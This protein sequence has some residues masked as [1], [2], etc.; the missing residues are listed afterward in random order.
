MRGIAVLAALFALLPALPAM[1]VDVK[2][3]ARK[4]QFTDIKISPGGE[5]LA[6]TVP[7]EDRT[8]LAVLDRATR[9]LTGTFSLHRNTHVSDFHWVGPQRLVIGLAEKFGSLETP[10]RTGELFAVNADGSRAEMLAGFRVEGSGGTGTHIAP[11]KD[12]HRIAA[13]LVDSVPGDGRTALVSV[14]SYSAEPYTSVES[15]DLFTGRRQRVASAPVRRASFYTDNR[16]RVRF[17]AGADSD[18]VRK[19]YYRKDDDAD[20]ELLVSD[21]A[22]GRF[23]YPIGFSAD[24]SVV[25][26]RSEQPDGPDA[27]VALDLA[28]RQRTQVLR[29]DDVDPANIDYAYYN[30]TNVIYRPGT[31]VPVGVFFMDGKPRI[32]FFDE[33]APE[34]R[35]YRSLEAAFPGQAVEITSQTADGRLALVKVSSDRNP[36]DFYLFDTAAKKADYLLSRREWFDPARQAEVRPIRLTARDGLPLHGYLTLPPG[37]G[38]KGLPM[39]VMPHGGPFGAQDVWGFDG[40]AQMLAEAGYAV[41]QLNFRGSGGYGRAF[42][43]AGAREWGGKMQD[44]LTDATR[45]AIGQGIADRNRICLYGA[46]YGAYASLMGLAK[47]PGLYKCAAGYVGVY[48]LPKMVAEDARTGRRLSNWSREWVGDK[49]E[50]LAANSPNRIAER[51]EAPVFLAAGGQDPFAPIEHSRLME[52]ALRKAGV[53]VETLYF[54]TEGHGFYVEAHREAFYARLLAFLSRHLGGKVATTGGG[55]N[56][57]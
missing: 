16:G 23:E 22:S 56:A 28:T 6:A 39:V 24:D 5:Y 52:Q 20:W 8:V 11:K 3:Y 40:D 47:E 29:D 51:I 2:A 32:A 43:I 50:V 48:D 18:N 36:G 42:R 49:P 30:P 17:A 41:L 4:D 54:D 26:L 31:R 14:Q 25:Y 19:L 7:L 44:D 46:S 45:W 10:Q 38:G 27:V 53:P 21:D 35:L 37:G 33:K 15:I 12:S 13:F 57:K 55:G 34:A 9:K 1:A